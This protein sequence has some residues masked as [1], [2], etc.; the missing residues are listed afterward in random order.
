MK[1]SITTGC[2]PK[3]VIYLTYGKWGAGRVGGPRRRYVVKGLRLRLGLEQLKPVRRCRLLLLL[4]PSL[5]LGVELLRL[6]QQLGLLLPVQHFLGLVDGRLGGR[7]LI[8]RGLTLGLL[9]LDLLQ[10]LEPEIGLGLGYERLEFV[11]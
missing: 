8:E 1:I 9:G 10:L 3:I 5:L 2:G 7:L 6:L 11:T 4:L